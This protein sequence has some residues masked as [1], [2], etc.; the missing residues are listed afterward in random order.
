MG[1]NIDNVDDYRCIWPDCNKVFNK[2]S[3]LNR[4][5]LIHSNLEYKCTFPNCN[6]IFKRRDRL[7]RH[8]KIHNNKD[9][10]CNYP[11]CKSTFYSQSRLNRHI[12]TV[13]IEKEIKV[14]NYLLKEKVYKCV[15]CNDT[16]KTTTERNKHRHLVHGI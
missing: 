4:H 1:D 6:S 13:H 5:L 14:N 7:N 15:S 10:S 12:K 3:N 16:F 2:L 8:V 11:N 9:I